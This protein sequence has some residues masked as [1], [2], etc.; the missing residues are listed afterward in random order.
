MEVILEHEDDLQDTTPEIPTSLEEAD[1]DK[2]ELD[3]RK[4]AT[5]CHA[6]NTAYCHAFGLK[7]PLEWQWLSESSW[8]SI[9]SGVAYVFYNPDCIP[10]DLHEA[11]VKNRRCDGW[12]YGINYSV[13][14]KTHPCL[15]PYQ[16]LQDNQK[17]KD[18]LFLAVA[19]ALVDRILVIGEE[20]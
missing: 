11:W 10:Q 12:T 19:G 3:F 1:M 6:A 16:D 14:N 13:H 5:I 18:D 9:A 8:A 20:R 7:A 15:V 4:I 17:I 2:L